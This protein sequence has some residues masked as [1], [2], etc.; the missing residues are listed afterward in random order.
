M[1]WKSMRIIALV[2]VL[3]M[4]GVMTAA[5]GS[6]EPT[7]TA[8]ITTSSTPS[9]T[10]T[11]A[12]TTEAVP[13]STTSA[14]TSPAATQTQTAEEDLASLAEIE[15]TCSVPDVNADPAEYEAAIIK[16]VFEKTKVHVKFMVPNMPESEKMSIMV[17]SGELPDIIQYWDSVL[18]NKMVDAGHII[19]LDEM[20]EDYAPNLDMY[21]G[22]LK[23]KLR[24]PEDGKIYHIPTGY[25]ID[26]VETLSNC[27]DMFSF[28]SDF[29]KESGMKI[30]K[31]Y[32]DFYQ[33]CKA[34]KA[35]HPDQI[36]FSMI[37]NGDRVL[38][39]IS[40][41][42][43]LYGLKSS[44][45]IHLKDDGTLQYFFKP[46]QNGEFLKL[47]NTMYRE[48]LM[49]REAPI[50]AE[51]AL[52]QKLAS[53]KVFSTMLYPY[54]AQ[55]ATN[56]VFE[57]KNIDAMF[58]D[59]LDFRANDSVEKMTYAPYDAS[60]GAGWAITK[61]CKDPARFMKF[62][63]WC[64]TEE[65]YMQAFFG[66]VNTDGEDKEG[67]DYF[68][69]K[70]KGNA[71]TGTKWA[72]EMWEKDSAWNKTRGLWQ[73]DFAFNLCNVPGGKY[74]FLAVE[75]D[76][77]AWWDERTT[78]YHAEFGIKGTDWVKYMTAGSWDASYINNLSV[79]SDS[80]E[81]IALQKANQLLKENIGKIV[82]SKTDDAFNLAYAD[83]LKRID[84]AG[85]AKWEAKV[86]ELY[87]QRKELWK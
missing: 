77:S 66:F 38:S 41:N 12:Q 73:L 65:G 55:Q 28:R 42:M 22:K 56:E 75:A 43:G 68:I 17:A 52:K 29:I 78:K 4:V 40:T 33:L 21:L 31:N 36:P 35:A 16:N 11:P 82:A 32:D 50:L 2:L 59:F 34:F 18:F 39:A 63:N 81:A 20:I 85:I 7:E 5:C 47:L 26:G 54:R 15:F 25:R 74:D 13:S 79:T 3:V 37:L 53:M 83:L 30:P 6:G 71:L 10:T 19:A 62:V 49:D 57:Q 69:D 84:D 51:D 48:G 86:N 61:A 58:L 60:G 45:Y 8:V 44:D 67:F 9:A 1:N 27:G 72:T 23:N 14:E 76:H 80:D 70:S 46:E 24:D 87:N 64:N